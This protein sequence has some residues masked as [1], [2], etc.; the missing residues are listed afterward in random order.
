M[1][2]QIAWWGGMLIWVNR[3]IWVF[4]RQNKIRVHVKFNTILYWL[5]SSMSSQSPAGNNVPIKIKRLT[6]HWQVLTNR[7]HY[8][9]T[10]FLDTLPWSLLMESHS[11]QP[12]G[13]NYVC[14]SPS[15][16]KPRMFNCPIPTINCSTMPLLSLIIIRRN[17]ESKLKAIKQL[18]E[19]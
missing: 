2:W 7:F 16:L 3:D 1:K 12:H 6:A 17:G 13:H 14:L 8:H 10:V 15:R 19:Y 4:G 18:P 5:T 9:W 11:S